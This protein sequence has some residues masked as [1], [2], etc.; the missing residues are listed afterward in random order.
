MHFNYYSIKYIFKYVFFNVYTCY[1]LFLL[2]IFNSFIYLTLIIIVADQY[3]CE[4]DGL[5]DSVDCLGTRDNRTIFINLTQ[6]YK[7]CSN[8]ISTA[9]Y[10]IL[11]FMP[12][13]L[14]EQFR[15]YSNCFF[16]LIALL[17]VSKI[18]KYTI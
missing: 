9:K 11:S 15:R 8:C 1:N 12:I 13:F 6:R 7:N 2:L 10:G 18:I 16:L 14:F 4:D 17:Q 3:G 5:P